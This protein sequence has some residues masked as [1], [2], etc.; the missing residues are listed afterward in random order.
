[1][2]K[3]AHQNGRRIIALA[4]ILLSFTT[5]PGWAQTK[6]KQPTTVVNKEKTTFQTGAAWKATTDSRA[7]VAIVYG[8]GGRPGQFE[9]RVKSWRD[10]GYQVAFMTG[11]AWGGY[12]DYFM[13]KWDGK[14]HFDEGQK[15][16]NGDTVWH[17]KNTPYV[18]PTMNFLKYYKEQVIK[19]VIDAGVD[20]IYLEEPEF[21]AKSGYSEGFKREWKEYY[22]FDWRPQHES[23]ENTYLS[24]KLKYYLFYRALKESFTYAKEYGKSK[25]MTVRC[26]VPTHSLIN[27][28]MWQIVSPEASLASLDCVDGYI[29]QSWTGTAREPTYFN[30]I[31]KERSF[32]T[33][34]LE[35]CC[36]KSMTAPTGRKL[37][38]E[39]D[40]VEDTRRDWSDYKKNYQTTFT[41]ELFFPDV[42]N[43]EVMPWPDRIF[44]GKY[45]T[46]RTSNERAGMPKS[47]S[48]QMM[49]MINSLNDIKTSK[50]KTSGTQGISVMM[51]NSM[52]FQRLPTHDD[53]KAWADPYYTSFYETSGM[54]NRVPSNNKLMDPQLSNFFGEALPFLKRGVPMDIVHIEN[55][56]YAKALA[57]TKILLMSYSNMKPLTEEPHEHLAKWVR[58]GGIIVYSG[59]D[60]D[61]FQSV[62]EWWNKGNKK[63]KCPADDLFDKLGIGQ[64]PKAGTYTVGKGKIC[65]IRRDPKEFVMESD[66]DDELR[67]KVETLYQQ[68]TGQKVEYKNSLYL[69]RGPYE[70][71]SV[72]DESVNADPFTIKGKLIDLFD[73]TLPVIAQKQV[74]P[75]QQGY[76]YNIDKVPNPQ[77]PQVLTTA[78]RVYDEQV[79]KNSYS[80]IA[81]SPLN[82]TNAMRVLLPSQP[83]KIIVTDATGKIIADVKTSW[84][85]IGKTSF[86]S[87]DNSPDGIKVRLEW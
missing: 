82:T 85:A 42:D 66:R 53:G 15:M 18:V 81:K 25:G 36:M 33:A 68:A 6:A 59:R 43:Y 65:I 24:N 29:V 76:L 17:G 58:N 26:Y 20:A 83:K 63:Y 75:G 23:A 32:E 21:W 28:S 54:F 31:A 5:V 27:Y 60:D 13:G 57:D 84:D 71:I 35:Y 55:V 11:M 8:A 47:Y 19:K 3:K 87:F 22:G 44:D 40:P 45:F 2:S 78:A 4:I 37:F 73:P 51:G 72:M 48:T 30:G 50:N 12:Q 41:A 79:E 86:L 74:M 70:I 69:N 49:V 52:M 80:F 61:A 1:M 14:P 46:S 62:Q 67:E 16:M 9:Q 7:D 39:N 38:F 77:T 64:N 56:G 10:H 34:F